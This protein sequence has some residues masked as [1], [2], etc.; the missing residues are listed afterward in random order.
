MPNNSC[1]FTKKKKDLR[2]KLL[3]AIFPS[4]SPFKVRDIS[5]SHCK[6]ILLSEFS[7]VTVQQ[8]A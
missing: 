3:S 4:D 1:I 8:Q 7:L 5:R 6:S 2:L